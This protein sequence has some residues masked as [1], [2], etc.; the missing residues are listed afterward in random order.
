LHDDPNGIA[1]VGSISP[2]G[3]KQRGPAAIE[4]TALS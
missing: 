4:E 3:Q 1:Y 2:F